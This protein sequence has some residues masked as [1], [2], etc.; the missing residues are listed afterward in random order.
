MRQSI[1]RVVLQCQVQS[2]QFPIIALL[3]QH[4]HLR[5]GVTSRSSHSSTSDWQPESELTLVYSGTDVTVGSATGWQTFTLDTPYFY[6]G[7]DN[8]VVVVAKTCDDYDISLRY[9]YTST[10]NAVMYRQGDSNLSYAEY[11]TGTGTRS[12]YAANVKFDMTLPDG[13]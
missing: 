10:S 3:L 5:H 2:M 8:L 12:S 11:P 4:C 1:R 6:N 13:I 7:T 9:Y